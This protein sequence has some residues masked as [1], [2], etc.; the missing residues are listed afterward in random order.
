MSHEV[1][2]MAWAHQVPWHGLGVEVDPRISTDE[3]LVKAGLNWEVERV[4]V[5]TADSPDAIPDQYAIRR[6]TD[7]RVFDI[8]SDRWKPVQNIEILAFFRDWVKAGDA[9]LETAGSLRGGKQVWA[10][11][12]LKTGFTLRGGDT[13]KGYVLM[14]GSHESGKATMIRTTGIRVVCANTMALALNGKAKS[15]VRWSHVSDFDPAVAKERLGVSREEIS[16]YEK[17]AR[18]LQKIKMD[19]EAQLK[20]LQP[21]FQPNIE[22]IDLKE[23]TN[24]SPTVKQILWAEKKAPGAT[25]GS[26]W[27]LLNGVTYALDHLANTRTPDGKFFASQ[28]GHNA[29]RKQEVMELLLELV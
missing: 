12:N 18:T 25:P 10:L 14:V 22:L 8:V 2:T 24:W 19:T 26:A 4:P 1:E 6:A 17:A 16:A 5:Y 15:E 9:T 3:M 29:A 28:L 11:A 7:K 27:G 23:E 20:I 13:I 21:V